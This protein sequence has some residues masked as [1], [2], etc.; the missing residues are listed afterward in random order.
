[1]TG[2]KKIYKINKRE[3]Q[4]TKNNRHYNIINLIF[5]RNYNEKKNCVTYVSNSDGNIISS[6]RKL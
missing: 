1:M 2:K 6:L 4:G 5:G 3:Q